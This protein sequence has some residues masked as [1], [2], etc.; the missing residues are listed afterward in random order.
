MTI[1]FLSALYFVFENESHVTIQVG[2]LEGSLQR[3]V[4]VTLSTSDSTA[5]GNFTSYVVNL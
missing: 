2:I 1:G 5:I 3:E 4:T